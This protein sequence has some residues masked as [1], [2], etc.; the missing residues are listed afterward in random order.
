MTAIIVLNWNGYQ[1]TIAC[2]ESLFGIPGQGFVWM[3]VDNGSTDGSVDKISCWLESQGKDF[4]MV[5]EGDDVSSLPTHTGGIVY[6]LSQNYGFAKGN[7]L[8]IQLFEELNGE[9]NGKNLPSHYLLLNNDTL[10]EPDFLEKLESFALTHPSYKALTPQIRYADPSDRIWNCGGKMWFGLRKYLYGDRPVSEIKES[11]SIDIN[12]ITGCAL[13]VERALL[14]DPDAWLREKD[15]RV[16]SKFPFDGR[17][18]LLTE[19]FFF[20]EEDFDLSLRIGESSFKMACVLDSVIYHK[21]G[22]SRVKN[23]KLGNVYVHYLNRFIDVRQ[24][25]SPMKYFLW[26]F[27]YFPY[28]FMLLKKSGFGFR[29]IMDFIVKLNREASESDGVSRSSFMS[30]MDRFAK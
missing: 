29:L 25:W 22:A 27:V 15:P 14:G 12:L 30:I 23:V 21:V 17:N 4:R 18:K 7:N 11:G 8:G 5:K 3:V 28:I 10:V 13:F 16:R 1:D 20:G 9:N 24:H 26:K 6:S 2:L 19:R